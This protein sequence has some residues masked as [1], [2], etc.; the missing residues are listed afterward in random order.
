MNIVVTPIVILLVTLNS[1]EELGSI[2]FP[3]PEDLNFCFIF[4]HFESVVD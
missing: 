3:I 4:F 1:Q 2:A